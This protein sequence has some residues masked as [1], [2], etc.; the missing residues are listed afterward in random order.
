VGGRETFKVNVRLVSATNK[1]LDAMVRDG[2]FREDLLYRLNVV[3]LRVPPL[4][5]RRGD[6]EL[7]THHLL[8]R[9]T[10]DLH[11]P[12]RGLTR[13]TLDA[14]SAYPWP[15]NV[16]ELENVLTRAVALAK[17]DILR[18]A[19]LQLQPSSAAHAN[20]EPP[21]VTLAEMERRHIRAAL[22]ACAWN[23]THTAERLGITR[24]TLRK[25]IDDYHLP[26]GPA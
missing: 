13:E 23:I 12:I 17:D 4:R 5:E 7:L 24:P 16:R 3:T 10:R 14:L 2:S 19:D 22:E 20:A 15:G 1:D 21:P 11:R 25:K 18:P 6:L 26:R 8:W 9:I